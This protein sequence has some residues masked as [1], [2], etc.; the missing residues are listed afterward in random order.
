MQLQNRTILE[1]FNFSSLR[2]FRKF[3][4]VSEESLPF[5]IFCN[6]LDFQNATYRSFFLKK[7]SKFFKKSF[8]KCLF[9]Y[10]KKLNSF[11]P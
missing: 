2:D 5:L 3:F 11:E 9:A 10:L 7:V 4:N 8:E 6:E 1:A